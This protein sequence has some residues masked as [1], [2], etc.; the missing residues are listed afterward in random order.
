MFS[1]PDAMWFS[2]NGKFL[3]VATFN[4]T[5]VDSTTFP[6]YGQPSDFNNQYPEIIKFKYPK[7]KNFFLNIFRKEK[8][9]L[10][11]CC[12]NNPS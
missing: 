9:V 10:R 3:A 2:E 4:D 1:A 6:Y 5:N 7:V 12:E 11:T 8:N